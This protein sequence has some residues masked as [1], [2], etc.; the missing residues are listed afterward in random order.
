MSKKKKLLAAFLILSVVVFICMPL[1]TAA[2]DLAAVDTGSAG[3]VET[4]PFTDL[5]PAGS[6]GSGSIRTAT[7]GL[8]PL[9]ALLKDGSYGLVKGQKWYV[10]PGASVSDENYLHLTQSGFIKA[11]KAGNADVILNGTTC[12]VTVTQPFLSAKSVSLGVGETITVSLNGLPEGHRVS[13]IT[14]NENVAQV[15]RGSIYATGRGKT[16]V[17]ACAGGKRFSV[18]VKVNDKKDTTWLLNLPVNKL[19]GIPVPGASHL[20]WT[21]S[22]NSVTLTR[23]KIKL[24]NPGCHTISENSGYRLRVYGNEP[25]LSTA[26]GLVFTGKKN[27]YSLSMRPGDRYL[28]SFINNR[29]H[30]VWRSSSPHIAMADGF[31]I[32]YALNTGSTKL[33]TKTAGR[34]IS[35]TVRVGSESAVTPFNETVKKHLV[36]GINGHDDIGVVYDPETGNESEYHTSPETGRDIREEADPAGSPDPYANDTDR[37]VS[38]NNGGGMNLTEDN[39]S[40]SRTDP[41]NPDTPGNP[42][43]S[44]NPGKPDP[45][46]PDNAEETGSFLSLYFVANGG[47]CSTESKKVRS[48]SACGELPVP[49]REHFSFEGWY[50][51]P[52]GGSRVTESTHSGTSDMIL[53][54]HWIKSKYN[55]YF[56]AKGGN[57]GTKVRTLEYEEPFGTLP[58]PE[59]KG[60][61]FDGWFASG[62]IERKISSD[63]LIRDNTTV[64][65][66]WTPLTFIVS[67]D[68][69]SGRCDEKTR[70]VP[71]DE[72]LGKLPVPEKE[73]HKFL[74]WFTSLSGGTEVTAASTLSEASDLT[75]YAHWLSE[76]VKVSFDPCGGSCLTE[77]KG[78]VFGSSY[79]TLPA[80]VRTGYTFEGWFSA[81]VDG[82]KT[83]AYTRVT[84]NAPHTLYARWTAI[85]YLI[86]FDPGKG[87]TA[88]E[89]KLVAFDSSYGELP[90]PERRGYTFSGWFTDKEGG[91]HITEKTILKEAGPRTLYAGWKVNSYL[92]TFDPNKGSCAT[93][94]KTVTYDEPYGILPTPLR[95]GYS[96]DGWHTHP[97]EGERIDSSSTVDITEPSTL[98]AHWT[99]ESYT[100]TFD[101]RGA[102]CSEN[103]I[104]VSYDSVY[105][106]LPVPGEKKGY[107]FNGWFTALSGGAKIEP[108]TLVDITNDQIL[109]A[110]WTANTYKVTFD[111]NGGTCGTLDKTVT[112]DQKYEELPTPLREGYSHTGWYDD[113][114]KGN[115][116]DSSTLVDITS[117][118]ILYAHWTPVAYTITF[119]TRGGSA[120]FITKEVVFDSTYGNLPKV[121]RD[122]Y[123]FKGWH[124][125]TD[126]GGLVESS[127]KVSIPRDH[128]LYAHWSVNSY[129]VYFDAKGG[130]CST[131]KKTV[132]YDSTYSPL[133]K[134]ERAGYTFLG[135][136]TKESGGT[137]ITDSTTVKITSDQTFYAQ[138]SVNTYTLTFRGNGGKMDG[139]TTRKKDVVYDTVIGDLPAASRPG[140]TFAGWF[141]AQSGGEKITSS[142][143]MKFSSDT[144]LYA[145]WTLYSYVIEWKSK[146]ASYGFFLESTDY[147]SSTGCWKRIRY[148]SPEGRVV[149][150]DPYRS[151]QKIDIKPK[152]TIYMEMVAG[153]RASGQ[154]V[155]EISWLINGKQT[156][157]KTGSE[158]V[159]LSSPFT[160]PGPGRITKEKDERIKGPGNTVNSKWQLSFTPES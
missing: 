153:D 157:K 67:F 44:D 19:T 8:Q 42:G 31:G 139:I 116:I 99:P 18:S 133:P 40:E 55:L 85:E 38:E 118:Q 148:T 78:V 130:S 140:Y 103:R 60:Y 94:D 109:Y 145:Q 97:S 129:T 20:D 58:Q 83:E 125:T 22:S 17:S 137:N 101:A 113:P 47:K 156:E 81:P 61:S 79:G 146:A 112:Y 93:L 95:T 91:D 45:G 51:A 160:P 48:K 52:E 54:A 136:Y 73:G 144:T 66:H 64:F 128:T 3:M 110:L 35:I 135:W 23:G 7:S 63:T 10:G 117:P 74:G 5:K 152:S 25:D 1:V 150:A 46:V 108:S 134:T 114:V 16:K 33:T 142:T 82:I 89:K 70:R 71:F 68:A 53:Y 11:K 50:S 4:I 123:T 98:Y 39:G 24:S 56:D 15:V 158:Y 122:G 154:Y 155:S 121:T 84:V 151:M 26:G 88:V 34:K 115:K 27:H 90:V 57:C 107:S 21:A 100:V 87:T 49:E 9:P 6:S 143:R 77:S 12:R 131:S 76:S 126:S 141:T 29:E 104:T 75:L 127:T 86:T 72:K 120:E 14:D 111:P 28:L 138:W 62:D 37:T 2:S 36:E 124:T 147:S 106:E 105:G 69:D 96:F 159:L 59:K 41:V 119:D 132:T 149:Y 80:A 102:V 43:A 92:L 65:A 30:P 13:W 32:V